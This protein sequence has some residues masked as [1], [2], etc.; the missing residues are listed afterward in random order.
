MPEM[1]E[2]TVPLPPIEASPNLHVSRL[3]RIR[4]LAGYRQLTALLARQGLAGRAWDAS[5]RQRLSLRFRLGRGRPLGDII[6]TEA[7]DG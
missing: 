3:A 4:A 1:F 7:L 2:L 5:R 6:D